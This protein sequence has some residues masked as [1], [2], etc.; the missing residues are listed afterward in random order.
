MG[1]IGSNTG[2]RTDAYFAIRGAVMSAPLGRCPFCGFVGMHLR[3][4]K[5]VVGELVMC[6]LAK[7][8]FVCTAK[9]WDAMFQP[10]PPALFGAFEGVDVYVYDAATPPNQPMFI[11][12]KLSRW[13]V[14][15]ATKEAHAI[16][17]TLVMPKTGEVRS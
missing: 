7:C 14:E 16:D 4:T 17:G 15:R 6:G 9:H 12:R 1:E 2:T 10:R 5:E 8:G 11:T 13:I 3:I